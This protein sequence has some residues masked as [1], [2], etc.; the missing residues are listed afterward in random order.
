MSCKTVLTFRRLDG[1]AFD[2]PVE[3]SW[4]DWDTVPSLVREST[5]NSKE[6]E[7]ITVERERP[8]R[9]TMRQCFNYMD[10][11]GSC[12]IDAEEFQDRI[13]DLLGPMSKNRIKH[14]MGYYDS[15]GSGTL[16]FREFC[17]FMEEIAISQEEVALLNDLLDSNRFNHHPSERH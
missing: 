7:C 10:T 9:E 13:C 3:G 14:I 4:C 17:G 11:D 5:V 16:D 2:Y 15:D 12:A 6:D 8:T 1:L